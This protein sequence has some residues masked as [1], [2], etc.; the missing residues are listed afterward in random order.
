MSAQETIVKLPRLVRPRD[1]IFLGGRTAV[2]YVHQRHAQRRTVPA[3]S[4]RVLS[5]CCSACG[6]R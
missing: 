3:D 5:K 6:D 1:G 2:D 4:E